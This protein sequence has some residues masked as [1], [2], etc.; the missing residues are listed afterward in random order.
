MASHAVL[1]APPL[2]RSLRATSEAEARGGRRRRRRGGAVWWSARDAVEAA[3]RAAD[4]VRPPAAGNMRGGG[5]GAR[6]LRRVWSQHLGVYARCRRSASLSWEGRPPLAA[7]AAPRQPARGGFAGVRRHGRDPAPLVLGEARVRGGGAVYARAVH[8]VAV[9]WPRSGAPAAAAA[10]RGRGGA[11]LSRAARRRRTAHFR[12]AADASAEDVSADDRRSAFWGA[13]CPRAPRRARRRGGGLG[14]G[15]GRPG[16]RPGDME[17]AVRSIE[18]AKSRTT[19]AARARAD[20]RDPARAPPLW[21]QAFIAQSRVQGN[22]FSAPRVARFAK[23]G[24]D[25]A[26][27]FDHGAR[28]PRCVSSRWPPRWSASSRRWAVRPRALLEPPPREDGARPP[29]R[30]RRDRAPTAVRGRR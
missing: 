25:F 10:P 13:R 7:A 28:A 20:A 12:A 24:D 3:A 16:D 22:G 14:A 19:G 17:A 21:V 8:D 2:S 23:S 9:S 29:S 11:W 27:D 30:R 15:L 18:S 1:G 6:R 26:R 5:F 4:V